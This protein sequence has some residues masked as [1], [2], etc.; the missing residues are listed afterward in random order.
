MG[1]WRGFW[2]CLQAGNNVFRCKTLK[3]LFYRIPGRVE[4]TPERALELRVRRPG[5][6]CGGPGRCLQ[7]DVDKL[8][9]ISKL[10]FPHLELSSKVIINRF[11]RDEYDSP[12]PSF[13]RFW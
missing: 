13:P 11:A 1:K 8:F 10:Y 9:N 2:S 3:E 5:F 7:R 6:V 4:V 12:S